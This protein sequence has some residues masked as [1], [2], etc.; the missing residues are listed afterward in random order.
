MVDY[1]VNTQVEGSVE[2]LVLELELTFRLI[3]FLEAV[4]G[5]EVPTPED[6]ARLKKD[7]E[8]AQERMKDLCKHPGVADYMQREILKD[9]WLNPR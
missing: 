9:K 1:I 2:N 6:R 8:K 5:D 4:L 7:L 3:A